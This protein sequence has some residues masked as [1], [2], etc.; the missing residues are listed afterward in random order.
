MRYSEIDINKYFDRIFYINLNEN[1]ERNDNILKNLHE[2]KIVN[3]ERVEGEK[4]TDLP[5][6]FYYRNFINIDKNYIIGSLG[7]RNSHLKCIK[8]AKANNYKKILIFE[9]DI[10]IN[11]D[12]NSILKKNYSKLFDWDMIYF[13]GLIEHHFRNQIVGAF[14]YALHESL[15]DDIIYMCENSG[16][17]I[18]NFYA[19]IIQHMSYNKNLSGK[20]N[21]K[22]IEPFNLVSHDYLFKS[23]IRN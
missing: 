6:Y 9:D 14:A 1:V 15:F 10:T 22:I 5:D 4:V 8:I 18:D 11:S 23:N 13:G 17:E 12:I 16:M 2:F 20:Y 19:K 21:I 3:F 7:C